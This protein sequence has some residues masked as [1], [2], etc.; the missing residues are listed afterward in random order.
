MLA[1]ISKDVSPIFTLPEDLLWRIF[2]E[3]TFIGPD[4][5]HTEELH[6]P[7]IT[8]RRC[9]QVCRHWRATYLSSSSMRAKV[10]DVTELQQQKENWRKEVFARTGEALLWVY[11]YV[12]RDNQPNFPLVFLKENWKRVQLLSITYS[13]LS[14]QQVRRQK[15]WAFLKEHAP[16]LRRLK[17]SIPE[18]QHQVL[19]SCL[20]A[21]DAPQLERFDVLSTP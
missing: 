1:E 5:L 16:E 7:L 19:P 3:N 8:A 2:M 4:Y 17:I 9:S 10:V 14:M 15:M 13:V 12:L 6:S 11:G 20:F 18:L 21:D